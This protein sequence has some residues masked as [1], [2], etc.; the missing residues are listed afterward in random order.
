MTLPYGLGVFDQRSFYRAF[1][2]DLSS[3]VSKRASGEACAYLPYWIGALEK[4]EAACG[5]RYHRRT[6]SVSKSF[7]PS[8]RKAEELEVE[9][10]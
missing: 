1:T 6:S 2:Q 4:K 5:E 8:V 10:E 9:K 3:N 7:M